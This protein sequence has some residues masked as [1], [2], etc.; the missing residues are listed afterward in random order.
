MDGY[1]LKSSLEKKSTVINDQLQ[2]RGENNAT[3][4]FKSVFLSSVQA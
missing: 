4:K 3:I 1:L 2:Y